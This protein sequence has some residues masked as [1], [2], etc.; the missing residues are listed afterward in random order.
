MARQE[1]VRD[2]MLAVDPNEMS[3]GSRTVLQA[4]LE[5]H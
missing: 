2:W 1:P 4:A 3:R 5:L